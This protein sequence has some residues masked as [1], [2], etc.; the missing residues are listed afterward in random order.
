MCGGRGE[1]VCVYV[2]FT[3]KSEKKKTQVKQ[4]H[5]M[6]IKCVYKYVVQIKQNVC[7]KKCHMH[8]HLLAGNVVSLP[9][10][11]F[12]LYTL[13]LHHVYALD[14]TPQGLLQ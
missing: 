7:L 8:C 1:G 12:V 5:V 2:C 14:R 3:F 13:I 6:Y 10:E 4:S 11:S 9:A